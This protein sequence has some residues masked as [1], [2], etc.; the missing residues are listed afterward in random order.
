MKQT[1]VLLFYKFAD[2]KDTQEFRDK[3]LSFCINLE[4]KGRIIIAKEGIKHS[5]DDFSDE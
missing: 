3:T 2:I 4:L 5:V 1:K